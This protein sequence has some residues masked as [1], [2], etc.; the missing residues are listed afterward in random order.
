MDYHSLYYAERNSTNL[1]NNKGG[2]VDVSRK[3]L[4]HC[5]DVQSAAIDCL[6]NVLLCCNDCTSS[7]I[8][9]NVGEKD[10][11]AIWNDPA[12]VAVRLRIMRGK[13]PFEICRKC[14]GGA[15]LSTIRPPGKATR[16]APAFHDFEEAMSSLGLRAPGAAKSEAAPTT[17]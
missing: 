15:G 10:F 1:M 11:Y 9:G 13:W 8:F 16:L 3:P 5:R 4:A 2:M 6:G 12:F 14:A 17:R 7:Y